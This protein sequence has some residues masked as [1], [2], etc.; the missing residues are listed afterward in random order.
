[1]NLP[2]EVTGFEPVISLLH[3]HGRRFPFYVKPIETWGIGSE[4]IAGYPAN[5]T[6]TRGIDIS[7]S[8]LDVRRVP[9]EMREPMLTRCCSHVPM[10]MITLSER[11][12][13]AIAR[14][15]HPLHFHQMDITAPHAQTHLH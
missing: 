13:F 12:Y 6:T 11:P 10:A 8:P 14:H 15:V 4:S 7:R 5:R 2:R 9:T 3:D 1:M